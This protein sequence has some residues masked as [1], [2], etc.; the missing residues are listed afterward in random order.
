MPISIN[1]TGTINGISAGGLPDDCITTAD[2]AAN[3]VT[4]AKILDANITSVKLA[5]PMTLGTAQAAPVNNFVFS[6]IPSWAK[7]ISIM[8]QNISLTG[9][10]FALVRLG[11]S[12]GFETTGYKSQI[13]ITNAGSGTANSTIGF[14]MHWSENASASNGTMT[15]SCMGNNTWTS[16]GTYSW[17][18]S[19]GSTIMSGGSKALTTGV[20][21]RVQIL[22][23]DGISTF[24]TGSV[25]IMYEG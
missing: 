25:N 22:G 8:F 17:E 14:I 3:A 13:S 7:R 23:S 12:S 9:N 6:A 16:S 2:I 10:V 18:G 15:L 21:D 5:Q 11:T 20:L 24:D 4:T 19:T 1:G